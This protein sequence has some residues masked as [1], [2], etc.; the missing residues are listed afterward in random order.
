MFCLSPCK[1]THT[2][3]GPPPTPPR[4]QPTPVA[5][6]VARAVVEPP[7]TRW[8]AGPAVAALV[9]DL[10][11]SREEQARLTTQLAMRLEAADAELH[12]RVSALECSAAATGTAS[13]DT[14]HSLDTGPARAP[15]TGSRRDRPERRDTAQ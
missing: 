14:G 3:R 8:Y 10:A 9:A 15:P 4:R 11:A 5:A 6:P 13:R 1:D 12:G 7:S 2:E